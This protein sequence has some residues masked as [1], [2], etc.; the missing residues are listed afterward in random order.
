MSDEQRR[1]ALFAAARAWLEGDPDPETQRELQALID[2]GAEQELAERFDAPLAFGTAGL[3]GIVGAGVGR[4]N[5]AV[6]IRTTRGLGEFLAAR[7]SGARNLPVVIGYD[8]RPQSLRFAADATGVLLAMGIPVRVFTRETP[9]P[10]VAYAARVLGALAGVVITASHNP[11]EY[12]GYKIFL[13]DAIQLTSPA[14]RQ[15]AEMI[16]ALGPA[17]A[18]PRLEIEASGA[19]LA[20]VAE[21]VPEGL[22][23]RYLAEVAVALPAAGAPLR[24]AYSPL[25]GVGWHYA[26]R[27][28]AHAGF[29][30]VRV[31]PEQREPDGAFP[32]TP[33]PNPEEPG[34]MERA[35][36]F[37][38]DE[39]A[40]LLLVNDPDAD[41]LSAALP[42][43]SGRWVQLTGNQIAVLLADALLSRAQASGVE[44]GLVLASIV[45]TPL[46][47]KLARARG[48]H[49]EQ[50]LT[51]F[52][53]IW[54]AAHELAVQRSLR[55]VFACE[56]ALGYSVSPAVRDKDGISAALC[57]ARIASQLRAKD[58]SLLDR[59]GELYR[60]QGLWVSAQHSVVRTGVAGARALRNAV[61]R[62]A[63]QPPSE[64]SGLK[65]TTL[66]DHRV[67]GSR[68]RW[69]G[70]AELVELALEGGGRVLVRP[71]GTEPKLKI[72]V[73]LEL[74]LGPNA[75]W[76]AAE[77]RGR[78]QA[79]AVAQS[80]ESALVFAD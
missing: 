2:Q 69:L 4:M 27:A 70:T 35:L 33:F 60:E 78:A 17:R 61:D 28:L 57:L 43:A 52:K 54:T 79:L 14:D 32:S 73:D 24:I 16:E 31:V 77:E 12:N 76:R 36:A 18:V 71:S 7:R 3:R 58:Q 63:D 6:V 55:F 42:S 20:A 1:E 23:E 49:F 30:D 29:D 68:P 40:D 50:T 22:F 44:R 46:V 64:L 15:I 10:L 47:A 66:R 56:E 72:Y 13:D 8:A 62:L 51:G 19:A 9:T 41:R 53:W 45:S 38:A 67:P 34:S 59:L 37:A 5:R 75:A 48:A 74:E 39:K 25:H 21:P 65:V 11:R 26:Q 80:V